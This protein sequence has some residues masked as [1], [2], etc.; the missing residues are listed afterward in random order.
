VRKIPQTSGS[1]T[2]PLILQNW[3]K[4]ERPENSATMSAAPMAV[5]MTS[6]GPLRLQLRLL[7]MLLLPQSTLPS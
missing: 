1:P 2:T 7:P 6:V 4:A 5:T 3:R